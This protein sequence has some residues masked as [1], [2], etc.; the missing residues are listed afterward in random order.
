[1]KE[2]SDDHR[3]QVTPYLST[4]DTHDN[5]YIFQSQM[6]KELSS[7]L[8]TDNSLLPSGEKANNY[9]SLK[10]KELRLANCSLVSRCQTNKS[11]HLAFPLAAFYPVATMFISG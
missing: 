1:M 6:A 5:C 7:S 2:S 3:M 11:I 10:W 9:T 8:P 4:G